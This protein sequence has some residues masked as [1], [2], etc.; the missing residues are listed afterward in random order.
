MVVVGIFCGL[1]SFC[2]GFVCIFVEVY[3]V[4]SIEVVA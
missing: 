3:E 1:A 2:I 4:V